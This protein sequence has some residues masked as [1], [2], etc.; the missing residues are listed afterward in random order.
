MESSDGVRSIAPADTPALVALAE[1]TGVFKPAELVA[2]REVL[3]DYHAANAALAHRAIALVANERLVGFAYFAPAAMTD[4][5]W[6]LW[7]IAVARDAQGRGAGRRLMA[8]V[9]SAIVE[10]RGR[11]LLIETS[12]L[13]HYGPTRAFY[14]QLGYRQVAAVP[15]FYADG[16]HLCIFSKRLG[17]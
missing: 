1:G 8:W 14:E 17:P 13:D 9:E 10:A 15:D 6:N 16:D 4:R 11:C 5:N 12:S 3:D 2:L 7:W